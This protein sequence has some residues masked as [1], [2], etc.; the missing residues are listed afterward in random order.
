[1][2]NSTTPYELTTGYYQDISLRNHIN[3]AINTFTTAI[4]SAVI[5]WKSP[6]AMKTYKWF[7][8]NIAVNFVFEKI[9]QY[10]LFRFGLI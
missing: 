1:M 8:L 7:L 5:I 10:H 9:L 2:N 6:K 4:A 3:F